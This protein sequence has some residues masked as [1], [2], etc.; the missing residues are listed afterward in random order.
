[1]RSPE[2]DNPDGDQHEGCE[3]PDVHQLPERYQGEPESEYCRDDAGYDRDPVRRAKAGV[4][5]RE[6]QRQQVIPAH[7]EG[8]PALAEDQ[9]HHH[10]RE[11]D[12]D[13]E[14]DDELR[15]REGRRCE[16]RR[17]RRR[18]AQ[19]GVRHEP[20][21]DYGRQEV[22][23]R[24]YRQGSQDAYGHVPLG[25]AGL[26]RHGRHDVEAYEGEE[27]QRCPG[28]DAGDTVDRVYSEKGREEKAVDGATV[29]LS[30]RLRRGD[31]GRKVINLD[32]PYPEADDEQRHQDLDARDHLVEHRAQFYPYDQNGRHERYYDQRQPVVG[33]ALRRGIEPRRQLYSEDLEHAHQVSRPA[34][35][36]RSGT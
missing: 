12:E 9:D 26:L 36:D 10:H 16:G 7:G 15:G 29:G 6:P 23:N 35:G 24:A 2:D 31:E 11:P 5:P 13:R 33:E 4:D 20:G 34:L 32:K 25:V 22:E 3:R 18:G 30:R 27:D 28:E 17:R 1:M 21:K 14:R 19:L 8:Y